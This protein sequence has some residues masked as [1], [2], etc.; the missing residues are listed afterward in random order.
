MLHLCDKSYPSFSTVI[1][2]FCG[3][4]SCSIYC[5]A[6]GTGVK[7]FAKSRGSAVRDVKVYHVSRG[8]DLD[9]FFRKHGGTSFR[10]DTVLAL[11]P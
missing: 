8:V 4:F 9:P 2:L 11:A 3:S 7:V 1:D 6:E 5:L 10:S